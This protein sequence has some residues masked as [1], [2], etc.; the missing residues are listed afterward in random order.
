MGEGS[1]S[2]RDPELAIR[3]SQLEDGLKSQQR[4]FEQL[5][6]DNIEDARSIKRYLDQVHEM[7]T[8]LLQREQDPAPSIPERTRP[9]ATR[10][11]VAAR[12]GDSKVEVADSGFGRVGEIVL[13]GGQEARTVIGKSRLIFRSPLQMDYPEGATVGHLRDNEFLQLEGEDLHVYARDL[14]GRIH[15]VCSSPER[16]EERDD[17]QDQVYS[18]DLDQR[19]QRAVDARLAAQ[20]PIVS[21]G[22][23]PMIPPWSSA[24]EWEGSRA[25]RQVPPLPEFGKKEEGG[26]QYDYGMCLSTCSP[27]S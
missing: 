27:S 22:G 2:N 10:L 24:H 6:E 4:A 13:I 18:D 17:L 14:D 8:S 25:D 1:T 9:E 3:L 20:R 11:T 23:G 15:F 21:G 26:Q 7:V 5:Q 19:V 16:A 12:K